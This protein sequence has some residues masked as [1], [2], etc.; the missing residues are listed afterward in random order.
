M[1][2][3]QVPTCWRACAALHTMIERHTPTSVYSILDVKLFCMWHCWT[4][5]WKQKK[6]QINFYH[7]SGKEKIPPLPP[8][9]KKHNTINK[10][11]MTTFMRKKRE[12]MW[13][14]KWREREFNGNILFCFSPREP[15]AEIKLYLQTATEDKQSGRCCAG[16]LEKKNYKNNNII[17]IITKITK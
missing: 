9:P 3:F 11:L 16:L 7:P 5:N 14:E 12:K 17:T 8:S 2:N 4:K 15:G 13:R 1:E 6:P 10:I